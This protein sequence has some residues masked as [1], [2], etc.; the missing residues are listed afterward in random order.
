MFL[1]SSCIYYS[2]DDPKVQIMDLSLLRLIGNFR[3]YCVRLLH[4]PLVA[5]TYRYVR[6]I[7]K[8]GRTFKKSILERVYHLN[9][10]S[11]EQN[12]QAEG[13]SHIV[14]DKRLQL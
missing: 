3:L 1:F 10:Q 14:V 7:P 13:L 6:P 2:R 5:Y 4:C 8:Q 9:Y 11:I 12:L